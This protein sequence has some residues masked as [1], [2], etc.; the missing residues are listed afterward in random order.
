MD[1]VLEPDGYQYRPLKLANPMQRGV[2]VYALQTALGVTPDGW[3]GPVTDAAIR[4]AQTKYGLTVDGIAGVLTQRQLAIVIIKAQ[5]ASLYARLYG[6]VE[7][8]SSFWLG[9]YS[10][11]YPDHSRD[12]GVAQR[13][14]RYTPMAQGFDVPTSIRALDERVRDY[15]RKYLDWGV[16][17]PQAW[18]FAQGA[19]NSPLYADRLA[20]GDP[21]PD[22]FLQ[23]VAAV[24][25]YA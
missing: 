21:V 18:D 22:T 7:H 23:Y 8:E 3:L 16:K 1:F 11:P 10:A 24:S 14:T 12:C 5:N 2:D 13:N 19:W 4:K 6:Q 25:S 20:K 15:H 17:D 9:N